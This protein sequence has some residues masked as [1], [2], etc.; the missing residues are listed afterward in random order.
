LRN[1]SKKLKNSIKIYLSLVEVKSI[2]NFYP[3]VIKHM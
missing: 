3:I 2:N 1:V